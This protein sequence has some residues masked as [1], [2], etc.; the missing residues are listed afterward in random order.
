MIKKS[1][2]KLKNLIEC[3]TIE[4]VYLLSN[5]VKFQIKNY[6]YQPPFLDS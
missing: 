2:I 5:I 1:V 3:I 4:P 6:I